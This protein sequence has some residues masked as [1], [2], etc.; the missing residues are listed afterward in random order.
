MKQAD[1]FDADPGY[2]DDDDD[3]SGEDEDGDIPDLTSDELSDDDSEYLEEQRMEEGRRMFQMFAAKMFENR[4]LDA[5]REKAA[6]EAQERLIQE[7]EEAE[8]EKEERARLKKEKEKERKKARKE[9]KKAAKANENA[10]ALQAKRDAEEA[11]AKAQAQAEE[12]RKAEEAERLKRHA[13]EER[14]REAELK[15]RAAELK[16]EQEAREAKEAAEVAA[17]VAAAEAAQAKVAKAQADLSAKQKREA[18]AAGQQDSDSGQWESSSKGRRGRKQ[19]GGDAAGTQG[20]ARDS[21]G[22]NLNLS[23]LR[24]TGMPNGSGGGGAKEPRPVPAAHGALFEA[25]GRS[26]AAR[27]TTAAASTSGAAPEWEHVEH[28]PCRRRPCVAGREPSPKEWHLRPPAAAPQGV[29]RWRP[30]AATSREGSGACWRFFG[31]RPGQRDLPD[32]G[33][34]PRRPARWKRPLASGGNRQRGVPGALGAAGGSCGLERLGCL[35]WHKRYLGCAPGLRARHGR[36]HRPG[37]LQRLAGPAD[38][39]LA[40]GGAPGYP[41]GELTWWG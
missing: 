6:L 16:K 20:K 26:A 37:L 9:R 35:R 40:L 24:G 36:H 11:K 12:D 19:R 29:R 10:D 7:E 18:K 15:K 21:T 41:P 23:A 32:A 4:L 14:Q 3:L 22:P 5:Y 33:P 1:Y 39:E 31:N 17:R 34:A 28:S 13:D 2:D 8:K 27:A 25:P 30:A 38:R